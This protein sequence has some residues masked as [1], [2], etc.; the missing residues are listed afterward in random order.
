[1]NVEHTNDDEQG[2][3]I[4]GV[5][6]VAAGGRYD[7]LVGMFSSSKSDVP[8]VGISFGIERIFTIIEQK[9]EV[10]GCLCKFGDS[11]HI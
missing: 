5:G 4:V 2:G 1:L 8:C 6:S 10:C 11:L 3:T 7:K 9:F